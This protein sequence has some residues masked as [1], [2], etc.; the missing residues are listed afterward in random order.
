MLAQ[1]G[2]C[3]A[4]VCFYPNG[5]IEC[6]AAMSAT[7]LGAQIFDG[8]ASNLIVHPVATQD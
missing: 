8:H 1:S 6:S 7:R 5:H 2:H 3:T 4:H